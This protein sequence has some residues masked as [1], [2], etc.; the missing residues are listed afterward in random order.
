V[1]AF[2]VEQ[3][4]LNLVADLEIRRLMHEYAATIDARDWARLRA[5]LADDVVIEYH[6]G[7]TVVTGA[8]AVVAYADENTRHLAWQHH[9]VSPYA[10]DLDGDRAKGRTYLVSHQ[11]IAADPG[12]VLIMSGHYDNEYV[13]GAGGW[14]LARMIHTITMTNFVPLTSTPPAGVTIPPPVAP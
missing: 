8:A 1:D 11:M 5:V 6:T 3:R 13:R 14:R 4:V 9:L 2:D 10:I 12:H 7:R